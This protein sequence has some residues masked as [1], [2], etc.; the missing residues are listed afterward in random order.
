MIFIQRFAFDDGLGWR[1]IVV[2]TRVRVAAREFRAVA[3][4]PHI[5]IQPVVVMKP[6]R[7]TVATRWMKGAQMRAAVARAQPTSHRSHNLFLFLRIDAPIPTQNPD[8]I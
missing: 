5:E 8:Q 4:L 3:V 7:R 2:D 6:S 1:P